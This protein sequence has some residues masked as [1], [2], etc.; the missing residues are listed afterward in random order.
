MWALVWSRAPEVKGVLCKPS[1]VYPCLNNPCWTLC[2]IE[3][4]ERRQWVAVVLK[5]SSEW[6]PK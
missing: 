6:T 5:E 1:L 4:S 2:K 3:C